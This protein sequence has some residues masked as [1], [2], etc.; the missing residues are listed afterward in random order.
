M[1]ADFLQLLEPVVVA[2]VGFEADVAHAAELA[3][4][5]GRRVA[6]LDAALVQDDDHARAG[7]FDL[8]EDVRGKQ[9]RVLLAQVL[10]EV[11]HLADLV[12]IEADGR[13]VEDQQVGFGD[14]GFGEA[15]ALAVALWKGCR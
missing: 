10:D 5:V 9:D 12:R 3:K 1:P 7:H 6:G 13:L 14:E 4:Q 8:G 15:D 2:G 11:A